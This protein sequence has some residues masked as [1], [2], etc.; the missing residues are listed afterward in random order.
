[1]WLLKKK[2][3]KNQVLIMRVC[4]SLLVIEGLSIV[5]LTFVF[6]CN[7]KT[8]YSLEQQLT[9]CMQTL[10]HALASLSKSRA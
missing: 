6:F 7:W 5:L 8:M 1:M 3:Q 4:L 2:T 9:A 10:P